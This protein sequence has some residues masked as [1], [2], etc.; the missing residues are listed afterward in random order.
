MAP[1]R[2][3]CRHLAG[4][5]ERRIREQGSRGSSA[6]GWLCLT[7][8]REWDDKKGFVSHGRSR[9]H[10]LAWVIPEGKVYCVACAA[11]PA[12]GDEG[13]GEAKRRWHLCLEAIKQ[14]LSQ[15]PAQVVVTI[16]SVDPS[17]ETVALDAEDDASNSKSLPTL[18]W[19]R[20][21]AGLRN[22]G[23]TC[24]MNSALQSLASVLA[25][26][27]SPPSP[28]SAGIHGD[29]GRALYD[30]L[31]SIWDPHSS[32]C[33]HSSTA[34][35][36]RR[37]RRSASSMGAG[38]T[39][40]HFF[41][42]LSAHYDFFH[43]NEQQDSHDF[44][45][46]LFNALDDEYDQAG[47][48]KANLSPPLHRT[49]FGGSTTVRVDCRQ[50]RSTT[51]Q[52]E[53]C[54]DLSLAIQAAVAG[55]SLLLEE[56][57]EALSI[58]DPGK[59]ERRKRS[60]RIE[61]PA[62]IAQLIAAWMEP[63]EL[64]GENAFACEACFKRTCDGAAKDSPGVVYSPATCRYRFKR[65][66]PILILH[67]QRFS[68]KGTEATGRRRTRRSLSYSKDHRPIR[69]DP[70]IQL[71]QLQYQL[72]AVIVHEGSSAESG[73]YIAMVQS[74]AGDNTDEVGW[75]SISDSSVS[76]IAAESVYACDTPYI[77][78]YRSVPSSTGAL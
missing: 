46:L 9:S 58:Q 74:P 3:G 25:P 32:P 77:L 64:A 30:L 19:R 73:H 76:S 72:Q 7:C 6:T 13:K 63:Q 50:C 26:S 23:N 51:V 62:S 24:F 54:L 57:L 1:G 42:A 34:V 8:F 5:S 55:P 12:D 75:F 48:G 66:P 69:I 15:P 60:D 52:E 44:L 67:L 14:L 16:P 59:P 71:A 61:S 45:R 43:A 56:Q 28:H 2:L 68:L 53:S 21:P 29:L 38:I 33:S 20:R 40:H 35:S 49:V 36:G 70:Q 10:Q 11:Y 41:Q 31:A 65:P 47:G 27:L 37:G 78:F 4:L 22:L 39:P 18:P 17:T